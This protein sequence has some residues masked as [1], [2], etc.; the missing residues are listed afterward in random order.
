METRQRIFIPVGRAADEGKSPAPKMKKKKKRTPR[1]M[2]LQVEDGGKAAR[3]SRA[4]N[5]DGETAASRPES[6]AID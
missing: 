6:R 5:G 4:L 1:A 3:V 2:R